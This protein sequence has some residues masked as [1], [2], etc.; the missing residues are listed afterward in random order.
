MHNARFATVAGGAE[1]GQLSTFS[2]RF[3]Q[4]IDMAIFDQVKGLRPLVNA[5][6]NSLESMRLLN[7]LFVDA[8]RHNS[9]S[10]G[11]IS[12]AVMAV[13]NALLARTNQLRGG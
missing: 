2:T 7:E 13:A 9:G 8:V 5:A 3:L 11:V 12:P 4:R 10:G 6:W 1:V